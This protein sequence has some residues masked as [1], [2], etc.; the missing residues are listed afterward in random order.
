MVSKCVNKKESGVISPSRFL[1]KRELLSSFGLSSLKA[2]VSFLTVSFLLHQRHTGASHGHR[3]V[4]LGVGV[5]STYTGAS[6][7]QDD[8]GSV[9]RS[10]AVLLAPLPVRPYQAAFTQAVGLWD[11]AG[12]SVLVV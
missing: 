1:P 8:G 6:S 9:D 3:D 10:A 7:P 5:A 4:D 11:V 12:V 2:V